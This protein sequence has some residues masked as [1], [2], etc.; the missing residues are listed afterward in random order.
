MAPL[1]AL[2]V[3]V[4]AE[5]PK[6]AGRLRFEAFNAAVR[7]GTL[8]VYPARAKALGLSGRAVL[9]CGVDGEGWL[10][11]CVVASESPA[12]EGFGEAAM[13]MAPGF[14]KPLESGARVIIPIDFGRR[15]E[16]ED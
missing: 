2:L 11:A 13:K 4:A 10:E 5:P 3:L 16:A 15:P 8:Q 1:L 9:D 7:A 14:R 6:S 12:N